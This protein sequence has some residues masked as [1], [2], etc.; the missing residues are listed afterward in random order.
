M[1]INSF[2]IG[3]Q[4]GQKGSAGVD[5][6]DIDLFLDQINGE[7]IG[8]KKYVVT[9]VYGDRTHQEEV[10]EG[11]DCPDPVSA[12]KIEKP[13]KESTK[14]VNYIFSGWSLTDGGV[15]SSSALTQIENNV[16]VYAAFLE[17]MI[18]IAQGNCGDAA[19]WMLNPDYVM[20][21]DGTGA[22][23]S[24]SATDKPWSS[25]VNQITEVIVKP[26]ITEVGARAFEGC[27]SLS[28]I[29][30]AEGCK[31]INF[32]AFYNCQNLS[33]VTLPSTM[34]YMY[35]DAFYST[36]IRNITFP[37]GMRYFE[38]NAVPYA[39][40]ESITFARTDGWR[41]SS[42]ILS[43]TN[44]TELTP[45]EAEDSAKV[46]EIM[47]ES[48]PITIRYWWNNKWMEDI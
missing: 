1:D 14:Y 42:D 38:L 32:N 10:F 12:G 13:T 27:S 40:M 23:A 44:Y 33:T 43:D 29:S 5:T 21:I 31:K 24:Y 26:G 16:T 35:Q 34:Q 20:T 8:E 15:A 4:A 28:R 41:Y 46:L 47:R 30:L 2:L 19:Y 37:Y 36:S 18:Y 39:E 17:E 45:E 11:R 3:Y 48:S 7:I 6:E 9:F 25:Y 22:M